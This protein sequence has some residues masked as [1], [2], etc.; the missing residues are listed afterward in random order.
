MKLF[1]EQ[2]LATPSQIVKIPILEFSLLNQNPVSYHDQV[3]H[4][5]EVVRLTNPSY[6]FPNPNRQTR[7]AESALTTPSR[8]ALLNR[9]RRD[10]SVC[11]RSIKIFIQVLACTKSVATKSYMCLDLLADIPHGSKSDIWSLVEVSGEEE[12]AAENCR[13]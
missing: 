8:I 11:R 10:S 6:A 9:L 4:L 5:I 2:T 7:F 3:F 1:A 13:A 12:Y